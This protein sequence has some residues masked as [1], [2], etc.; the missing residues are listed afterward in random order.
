MARQGMLKALA[1]VATMLAAGT[2]RAQADEPE[3][4]LHRPERLTVAVADE[5]LG[6]LSP[7][8]RTL[9]FA[10][11]RNTMSQ[12][13]AESVA[14]GRAKPL[15]DD[16]ADVTWPRVSP[17]GR[18]LL[19]VSFADSVLGQLCVR[20]LPVGTNRRC[21]SRASAA[22]QAEWVDG[23]QIL[24][25]SRESVEGDLRVLDVQVGSALS[26]RPLFDRNLT[27]PAVSPD[28]QWLVYV[29]IERDETRVGPAFAAHAGRRLEAVRLKSPGAPATPLSVDLPGLTGQPAFARDGHWIYFVQFLDD[30]NHD[31][32][33]DASDDGVLF[34]VPFSTGGDRPALGP[35]RQLTETTYNCEYPA[36]AADRLVATCAQDRALAVY[37][38]PLDGEV[39]DAWA[40]ERLAA[41]IETAGT[42][43]EQQLLASRRLPLETTATGRRIALLDLVMRDLDL[44][45][46]RAAEFYARH[47]VD[48]RDRSTMGLSSAVL[49]LVAQ[50]R[51]ERERERGVMVQEF[52]DRAR[53]RLSDLRLPESA[54]PVAVA[55]AH[56]VR[57]RIAD[58]IGDETRARSELEAASLDASAP[59]PVVE[60][61]YVRA[62]AL[63]RELDDR[64]AL[65]VACRRLSE[66]EGLGADQR[67]R[68]AQAAVRAMVRGLSRDAARAG[69]E[70]E[71]AGAPAGSELAF[72][73]D[74]AE[75]VL[76]MRDSD[77]PPVVTEKIL[78][79][80][81]QQVRPERRAAVV[82]EV[83]RRA[84]DVGAGHFVESL[85]QRYLDDSRPGTRERVN[86]ERR[87]RGVMTGR[88]LRQAANGHT[89]EARVDFDAVVEQTGSYESAV[90]SIDLRLRAGESSALVD[91]SY[92]GPTTPKPLSDFASAYVIA[93]E[94]PALG[95][96]DE[97][98]ATARALA[99]VRA[100]WVELRNQRMAQALDGALLH[101]AYIRT[102]NPAL[103]EQANVHYV[104]A[105]D[106]A[107]AR[108]PFRAMVLG[109][110]GILHTQAGNWRIALDYLQERNGLPYPDDAAALGVRLSLARSLLHVDRP[111]D[112]ADVADA[113]MA[114]VERTPDLAAYRTLVRDRDAVANL[115]AGRFPQALALY[116]AQ[117]PSID[118]ATGPSAGRNRF[119][120]HLGRAAAA[121]GAER[122]T[123][124]LSELDAIE[125]QLDDPAR[126][127]ELQWGH[128][129]LIVAV[130]AY[131]L[132][133]EGLR[134][135]AYRELGRSDDEARAIDERRA[136]LAERFAATKRTEY[137]LATMLAE[138]QLALN[139]ADRRDAAAASSWL[140]QALAHADDLRARAHGEVDEPQLDVLWAAAQV[141]VSMGSRVVPDLAPRLK[142]ALGAIA[143]RSDPHL[144]SYARRFEVF[145][146][147]TDKS[148]GTR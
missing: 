108:T 113:A 128:A 2:A 37:S 100:S 123:L 98:K 41:E 34:R 45:Y 53:Q 112:A 8:G 59:A 35:P 62:D 9:Y 86:A 29:P 101:E 144:G 1:L 24:L 127:A 51:A 92:A 84:R 82:D 95:G 54:S 16:D 118:A 11:N 22:V 146:P 139:A 3:G 39:P 104:V 120:A 125:R 12:V 134:A 136:V 73:I 61:Y 55:L 30:S 65:V 131:R 135:R 147:L 48:Q 115:A 19:Y 81:A 119:V 74:L 50:H 67:L 14:D 43:A 44:E 137:E 87:F 89:D 63:Y 23:S 94:L 93:R 106:A 124:A 91:A 97:A 68:Y 96:D 133:A 49:A 76:A 36:P 90:A 4:L 116:D 110:L 132:I 83:V 46:H 79:L 129:P 57:S 6:Q 85:V 18:R 10:S 88:A 69:L 122:P 7:D 17:D 32:V 105:L 20:D 5:L 102:G 56:V 47:V 15:F 21:L 140:R 60:A 138:T 28:G 77:P 70:R 72:A 126:T 141:S 58:S 107:R 111:G 66:N 142:A 103:A 78:A 33:V 109:L 80:Y 31:G 75:A 117:I 52:G 114:M 26:A 145:M 130:R 25:V 38:L 42:K 27:D 64:E 99:R 40:A 148:I 71:Q 121:V 13:F 143:S